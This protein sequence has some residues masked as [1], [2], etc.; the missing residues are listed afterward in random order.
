MSDTLPDI[1][2]D[3][4]LAAL[5][6]QIELGADEAMGEAPL[7]RF[8]AEPPAPVQQAAAQV[9][10]AAAAAASQAPAPAPAPARAEAAALA[11][12]ARDLE[13]LR[14]AMAG[15]EGC[16]LKKGARNLVFADG[17]PGARVMIVGEAPGRDE[18]VQGKPF[19]GR[20]GQL[21]DRMF[22]AIGLDR[23]AEDPAQ[24]LYITNTL[25]WRPPQNRDPSSDEM[26]MMFPFLARHIELAAPQVLVTMGNPSTKLLLDT[27]TGITRM[28]GRWAEFNGIPLLP[29][30][31]PAALLRDPLKKRDSWADLLSLKA[32]LA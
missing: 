30:F 32:R 4:A 16:A 26:A 29:M 20:S 24:A 31:H 19:V 11:S 1:S 17:V 13:A 3:D 27:T 15:F 25:P 10:V 2:S 9:P 12:A 28:R 14:T 7:D 8:A 21:L 23:A 18:D 5:I 22:A 6:W